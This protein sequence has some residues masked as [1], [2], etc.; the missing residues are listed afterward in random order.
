[1][2]GAQLGGRRAETQRGHCGWR[3]GLWWAAKLT[4]PASQPSRREEDEQ[5]LLGAICHLPPHPHSRVPASQLHRGCQAGSSWRAWE[6]GQ[7]WP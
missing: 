5:T 7:A 1:M 4:A 3:R 6:L 2:A